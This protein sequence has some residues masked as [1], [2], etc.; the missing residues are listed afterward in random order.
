MVEA[1][2]N[3]DF[4]VLYFVQQ[5]L[6]C[7]FLDSVTAFLSVVFNAGIAWFAICGIMAIFKKH[8]YAAVLM[9]IAMVLVFLVGELTMKNVFCRVRPCNIDPSVSL[10]VKA[11]TS[12]SFP[13]GHTGSSFAAATAL[14]LCNKK[15]GIPALVLAFII[16]LSR[17]YLFVHYPTDVLVGAIMGIISAVVVYYISKKLFANRKLS[18]TEQ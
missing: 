1:I 13:S 14:F 3:W 2:T 16:G 17:I 5:N 6:R 18:K 7:G 11:P 12:F 9:L 10:A 8:R 4:S 15:L